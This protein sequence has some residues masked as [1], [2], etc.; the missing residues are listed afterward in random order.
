MH[1]IHYMKGTR[2]FNIEQIDGLPT[3]CDSRPAPRTP[4]V[5]RIGRVEHFFAETRAGI[6]HGGNSAY[7]ASGT[8]HIQMPVWKFPGYGKLLCGP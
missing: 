1:D 8:D 4:A 2:F 6:R 5:Q 7:Y 3:H